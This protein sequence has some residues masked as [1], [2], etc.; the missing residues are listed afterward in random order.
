[1][2]H[3]TLGR[4]QRCASC[5]IKFY[6]LKKSPAVCPSC[7]T[8]FDPETLLKSRRGRAV[9]KEETA[10]AP[11]KTD[12]NEAD[13][14][15]IDKTDED[16]FENDDEVLSSDEDLISISSEDDEDEAEASGSELIDVLDD[17]LGVDDEPSSDE[18]DDDI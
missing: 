4:K 2:A 6:D 9:S 10:K 15:L 17:E 8:E 11:S 12:E 18:D 14:D 7:G 16:E 13:D 3:A 1:M 5:G